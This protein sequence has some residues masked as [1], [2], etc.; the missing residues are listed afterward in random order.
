MSEPEYC[1]ERLQDFLREAPMAGLLNPAVAKS[2]SNALEQIQREL[3]QDERA[4]IRQIDVDDVCARLHKIEDSSVRP[5][6]VDLYNKRLKATLTDYIAWVGDSKSFRS[7]GGDRAKQSK[8]AARAEN[9][10]RA[11]EVR[12]LEETSLTTSE[13]AP[14][15]LSIPLREGLSVFVHNLPLDLE[16]NEAQKIARVIEALA[17]PKPGAEQPGS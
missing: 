5:E 15:L 7:V 6:V 3:T 8:R 1:L 14:G 2:R 12:A 13:W 4:D 11:E 9:G 17:K 10:D 16:A